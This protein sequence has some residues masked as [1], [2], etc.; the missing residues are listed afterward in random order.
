MRKSNSP[1]GEGYI[2][3]PYIILNKPAII[4]GDSKEWIRRMEIRKRKEKI[5]KIKNIING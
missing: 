5:E 3:A 4:V 2:Y 1:Y